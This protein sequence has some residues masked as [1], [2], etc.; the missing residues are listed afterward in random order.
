V[1][2]VIIPILLMFVVGCEANMWSDKVV[3]YKSDVPIERSYHDACNCKGA[4]E[5]SIFSAANFR[6]CMKAKGYRRVVD[7][8]NMKIEEQLPAN[9]QLKAIKDQWN[10]TSTN[11]EGENFKRTI[12]V[13][14]N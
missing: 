13:A 3:W 7:W 11:A 14:G 8:S 4:S 10:I 9:I 5:N 1:K 2:K 12:Y 6:E